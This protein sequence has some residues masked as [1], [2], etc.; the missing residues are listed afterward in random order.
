MR[1]QP[2]R[3]KQGDATAP[4]R[5]RFLESRQYARD[6]NLEILPGKN[7]YFFNWSL[8]GSKIW[9][10]KY[11][12]K[13]ESME[14]GVVHKET[15][16]KPDQGKYTLIRSN[17]DEYLVEPYLYGG[18]YDEPLP[19]FGCG[20]GWFTFLL[21]FV[22]PPLWYYAAFLY[23]RKYSRKNPRERPGLG[24]SAIAA[25]VCTVAAVILT[26]SLVL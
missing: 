7:N 17:S 16:A 13:M 20:V 9:C 15:A 8:L 26:L 25:L 4:N 1:G 14:K 10:L 24:A 5:V 23:L 18:L 6:L 11:Q 3:W 19:C 22:F 2:A 12:F 21:G